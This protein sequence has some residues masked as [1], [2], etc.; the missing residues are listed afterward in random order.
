MWQ[1]HTISYNRK[2]STG[3]T[4]DS[5]S[6]KIFISGYE[7]TWRITGNSKDKNY[8]LSFQEWPLSPTGGSHQGNCSP[9]TIRKPLSRLLTPEPCHLL[10]FLPAQMVTFCTAPRPTNSVPNS[11]LAR[12]Y[13]T[14]GPSLETSLGN[15]I[16]FSRLQYRKTYQKAVALDVK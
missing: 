5:V 8:R 13:L 15:V 3:S 6:I 2:Q 12:V 10:Q 7:I 4:V 14:C 11:G 9:P 1:C 16:W